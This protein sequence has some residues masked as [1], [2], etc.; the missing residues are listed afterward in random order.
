[1]KRNNGFTLLEVLIVI[2]IM[3]I[4]LAIALPNFGQYAVRA[5]RV[6]ARNALQMIAS[7]ID[8]HYRVT[9]NYKILSDK[10]S[11]SNDTIKNWKLDRIPVTG[12]K[13]LRHKFCQWVYYRKRD[14][15]IQA[16]AAGVQAQRDKDCPYFFYDQSGAKMASKTATPPAEGSRDP[17]SIACWSK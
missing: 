10:T 1:M 3:G 2:A 11:L 4:L 9:R 6:E 5:Q 7:Q 12:N 15:V 8:Q 14:I 17:V 13:T 16:T